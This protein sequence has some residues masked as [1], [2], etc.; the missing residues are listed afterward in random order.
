MAERGG[1][2]SPTLRATALSS[3]EEDI[4]PPSD[5]YEFSDTT[6]HTY[7][8]SL[9][10]T[11]IKVDSRELEKDRHN[12]IR[13]NRGALH[14]LPMHNFSNDLVYAMWFFVWGS[15]FTTIIPIIPLIALSEDLFW[16]T[17]D[18]APKT[19]HE[20]L[21]AIMV[22]CGVMWTLASWVFGR[23]VETDPPEAL[24]SK[25]LC[26]ATDELLSTWLM[27]LGIA[28][29]VF[30]FAVYIYHNPANL[31]F[32]LAF[33]GSLVCT[34]L[35]LLFVY[36]FWPRQ[37]AAPYRNLVS[38]F[39]TCFCVGCPNS[40]LRRH[41]QNDLLV[42]CWMSVWGCV[43][44]CIGS[45]A[46][47][48]ESVSVRSIKDIYDYSTFFVDCVIFLVGCLYF[49]AASYP[50]EEGKTGILGSDGQTQGTVETTGKA[51]ERLKVTGP[52]VVVS[53][54]GTPRHS[55]TPPLEV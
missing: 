53:E 2:N 51:A 35:T 1:R 45:F 32:K 14:W 11:Q 6:T 26:C 27:F 17:P 16:E 10:V 25:I 13:R 46:L 28:P 50:G 23:A 12:R 31:E 8:R 41:V 29:G 52:L 3:A 20:G 43:V 39:L 18:L 48:V 5:G 34:L 54:P 40:S 55:S 24:L 47:F 37:R 38:P 33:I 30:I 15:L 19:E 49:T 7:F 22:F 44:F 21:Y 9:T 36:F 4:I 42:V